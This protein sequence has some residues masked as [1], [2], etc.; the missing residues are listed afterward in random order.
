MIK[1]LK[2]IF[3]GK[4]GGSQ[5]AEQAVEHNGFSIQP[6]PNNINGGWSTEAIISKII[7]GETKTHNFIR[8]DT[9]GSRDGAIELIISKA[10]MFIDQAGEKIFSG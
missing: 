5:R 3:G 6:T 1:I 4:N 8:A 7:N 9:S 10:K 2:S